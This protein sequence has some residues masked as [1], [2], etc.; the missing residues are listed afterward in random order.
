M[1]ECL[2]FGTTFV[3]PLDG[4]FL[5]VLTGSVLDWHT[6]IADVSGI[7]TGQHFDEE[8]INTIH[9]KLDAELERISQGTSVVRSAGL[10]CG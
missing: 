1:W 4:D 7:M 2:L 5:V 8:I 10:S 6:E 3:P 9:V